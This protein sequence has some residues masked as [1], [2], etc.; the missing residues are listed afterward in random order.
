MWQR[1]RQPFMAQGC[2]FILK[3]GKPHHSSWNF[4]GNTTRLSFWRSLRWGQE[5]CA[6]A[7]ALCQWFWG[8]CV[9][10]GVPWVGGVWF[11]PS[12]APA[13]V[14]L[15]VSLGWNPAQVVTHEISPP[16]REILFAF[17]DFPFECKCSCGS[18]QCGCVD[19]FKM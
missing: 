15:G 18:S 11:S 19:G 8:G 16:D 6:A 2:P 5:Y 10:H 14:L 13:S 12:G 4:S 3:N 9:G 17:K 1:A 7:P